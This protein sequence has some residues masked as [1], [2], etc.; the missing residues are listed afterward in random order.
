MSKIIS[1]YHKQPFQISSRRLLGSF[2]DAF[3]LIILTIGLSLISYNIIK[4][5]PS[6]KNSEEN[7]HTYR[8]ACYEINVEA[9]L[10]SFE[11]GDTNYK[12]PKDEDTLFL[13]YLLS[14]ILASYQAYPDE[15]NLAEAPKDSLK[16]GIASYDNDLFAKFFVNYLTKYN[17]NN[18]LYDME[19]FTYKEFF[20]KQII[21]YMIDGDGYA[22]IDN[23]IDENYKLLKPAYAERL[24]RYKFLNEDNTQNLV[25]YNYFHSY[26]HNLYSA[27][28]TK[29]TSSARYVAAFNQ[30]KNSYAYCARWI[31]LSTI[32]I[33][34]L[35][36]AITFI[37]PEL[38]FKE[39]QT[40]GLKINKSAVITV[41]GYKISKK[42]YALRHLV[43][44]FTYLPS[45]IIS[46]YLASGYSSGFMYPCFNIG[47]LN[48]SLFHLCCLFI[49]PIFID[50]LLIIGHTS[51]ATIVEYISKTNVV[52]TD[53]W[54]ALTSEIV[55]PDKNN[56]TES[57]TIEVPPLEAGMHEDLPYFDSSTFDNSERKKIIIDKTNEKEE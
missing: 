54:R 20:N 55:V 7:I 34:L 32:F 50:M 51:R 5:I 41:E 11:D 35:A 25:T 10:L 43:Q 38:I 46:C 47:N 8:N 14:H 36:F 44:L 23:T 29:L 15:F 22:W 30:Y 57:A 16:A 31:S 21:D 9:G 28:T 13:S 3:I 27:T 12:N 19:K 48:F 1:K 2:V 42:E 33:Y 56:I 17:S 18:N 24:Y 6:Y 39:G 49:V 53:D 37:V 4:N 45:L 26:F 40:I 52:S